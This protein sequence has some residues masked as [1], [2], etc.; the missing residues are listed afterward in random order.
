VDAASEGGLNPFDADFPAAPS[1]LRR[2][3]IQ[4]SLPLQ[5]FAMI[6]AVLILFTSS[7]DIFLVI[8]AAGNYRFCQIVL[9]PLIALGI[10]RALWTDRLVLTIGS[11]WLSVWFLFQVA[12]IP[13]TDFWPKAV[14]YCFWLLLNIGMMFC[15]V[16][17]FS[18]NA[19][20]IQ[21]LAKWYLHS[22]AFVA[23]FG[24]FQFLL[25]VS[26]LPG[27]LIA[28]WWIPGILPRVNGFSYEPSYFAC[29]L[30]IGFVLVNS[31]RRARSPL[32][33]SKRLSWLYY[34]IALGIIVSSSRL[35]IVF[36]IIEV[37]LSGMTP[38]FTFL[39]ELRTLRVVRS[40]LRS[41]VPSLLVF[42]SL[43]A[44]FGGAMILMRTNPVL[45][46]MFLNGTG[47]SDT[48]AHSVIQRENSL[49]E[50]I[51]VFVQ[52]PFI[53]RSLGGISAAIADHEGY[54]IRS[55]EDAKKVEGMSVFAEVL[56][57]S[58]VI[59][60]IP[61]LCFVVVT[62]RNPLRLA[63]IVPPLY[64]SLLRGL[65]RSL[66][67]TWAILQFNQNVLCT[68]LWAHLAILATV[69]AAA[70]NSTDSRRQPSGTP[71]E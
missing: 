34:L 65:V 11:L 51:A 19:R 17:L 20:A 63:R 3:C 29:Y 33:S 53:G 6:A 26:G 59:G 22:F 13:V 49:Q 35:G 42:S 30:L 45:L 70:L 66:V 69:Y 37:L 60:F 67:F 43:L 46:L 56:T 47:V 38:W 44:L 31:L 23:A 52:H 9:L 32:L 7:F 68:Y 18:D 2:P 10:I 48:A 14:G 5:R 50:T 57:A 21:T 24:I 12:F 40:N 39:S 1:P 36:L 62:I 58:G 61:F 64:A 16:Q 27:I 41:L 55:F 28:Q 8:N 15:F 4:L 54:R 71:H 25:P